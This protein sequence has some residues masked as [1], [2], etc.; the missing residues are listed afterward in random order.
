MKDI[1]EYINEEKFAYSWQNAFVAAIIALAKLNAEDEAIEIIKKWF[2]GDMN[3]E[4]KTFLFR[5]GHESQ[6]NSPRDIYN[7]ITSVEM[8]KNYNLK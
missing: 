7:A 6:G 4:L 5:L 1:N 8:D 2:G 3:H